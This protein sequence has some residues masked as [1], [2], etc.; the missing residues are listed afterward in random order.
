MQAIVIADDAD[1]KD[2]FCFILRKVGLGVATSSST[3]RVLEN[4]T[5]HPVDLMVIVVT[6]GQA[7][8]KVVDEVRAITQAPLLMVVEPLTE[9]IFCAL[10]NQGAD[11]VLRRPVSHQEL[12]A[13]V[14]VL[15]RRSNSVP[16]F[17]MP[18][19]ELDE[20]SLDPSNRTVTLD[21]ADPTRLTRLEFRLL[22]TLM[23]NRG[24]VIPTEVLVERIWGYSGEGNKDLVR[25]LI[26]R[27]RR[28]IEPSP[29]TTRFIETIPGIG[30]RFTVDTI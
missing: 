26:N 1:E 4:F 16:S 15:M 11:A 18:A 28:K 19:I 25:G 24:Q 3:K 5:D 9:K 20:I 17:V 13:Q 2:I 29:D 12:S 8:E 10:L 7:P 21:G 23:T 27:L 6:E 22:Y 30:Y 14:R